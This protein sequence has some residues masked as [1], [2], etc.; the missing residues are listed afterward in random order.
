MDV[1]MCPS[2]SRRYSVSGA[3][4]GGG[5]RCSACSAELRAAERDVSRIDLF[6]RELPSTIADGHLHPLVRRGTPA[7]GE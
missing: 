7:V 5:W 6:G 3:G 1:L 2:C 4:E